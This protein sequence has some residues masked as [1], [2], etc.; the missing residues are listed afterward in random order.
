MDERRVCA[1]VS[2]RR[3]WG[4]EG[5]EREGKKKEKSS[6]LFK[7]ITIGGPP[8]F[9][10]VVCSYYF[11]LENNPIK[12]F[13]WLQ[14]GQCRVLTPTPCSSIANF[15]WLI[16]LTLMIM[17][18]IAKSSNLCCSAFFVVVV[19][20]G[21]FFC[22]MEQLLFLQHKPGEIRKCVCARVFVLRATLFHCFCCPF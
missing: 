5:S 8:S 4:N 14:S 16:Q 21:F 19:F 3:H 9:C 22:L 13:C 1:T 15:I 10:L 2:P 20:F 7:P 17:I 12:R 11:L 18:N 6:W